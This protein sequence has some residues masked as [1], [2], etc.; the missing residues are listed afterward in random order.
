MGLILHAHVTLHS[1]GSHH[2]CFQQCA[3]SGARCNLCMTVL[4]WRHLLQQVH[5]AVSAISSCHRYQG[6]PPALQRLLRTAAGG[7]A[8]SCAHCP[9]IQYMCCS[10]QLA[11]CICRPPP[12]GA[13]AHSCCP[14][15]P[16]LRYT[17]RYVN[18][19]AVL[20]EQGSGEPAA[21]LTDASDELRSKM[22]LNDLCHADAVTDLLLAE[23]GSSKVLLSCSRDGCIK[24]WK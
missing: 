10:S 23:A 5:V 16:P 15:C 12:S 22:K 7:P 6:R 13:H 14:S 20:E 11:A 2:Q 21:P 1:S 19:V 4:S 18:D 8:S 3:L 24:A 9:A 17:Q